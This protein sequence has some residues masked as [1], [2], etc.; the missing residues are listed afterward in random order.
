MREQ[1]NHFKSGYAAII[2]KP[3]VGKSTLLNTLL[4]TKM[5]AV[6]HKP[7][8]TRKLIP[9]IYNDSDSQI[10]FL[11]TPGLFEPN[12][13]LQKIMVKIAKQTIGEA[14]IILYLIDIEQKAL[15]EYVLETLKRAN[16]LI[17]L[18]INKIDTIDKKSL[19]PIIDN[20][21]KIFSFREIIPISALKAINTDDIIS[22]IKKCLSFGPP[23]FPQD[24]ISFL[25]ERFFVSDAIREQVFLQ[26]GKEIP[27]CTAVYIDEFREANGE[28]K[29]YI[30][31]IILV[32][33]DSQKRILI[34][35]KGDAIKNLGIAARKNIE[36]FLD[37]PV[38]LELFVK[39][40]KK[41]RENVTILRNIG[42]L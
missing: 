4:S 29:D 27:Y 6:T 28:K 14:D 26:Y 12:Y 9:A 39:T 2:G 1:N 32:E 16:K 33:R 37:R 15:D 7:Q 25:P 35:K 19:L 17:F 30:R 22:S 3:N 40:K 31:A 42:Y 23:L 21:Q 36:Q 20:A 41:W 11:D 34:G 18:I 10:I 24:T 5:S 8:T 13:E 38:F